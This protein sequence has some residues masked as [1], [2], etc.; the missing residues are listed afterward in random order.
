MNEISDEFLDHEEFLQVTL[1]RFDVSRPE[2]VALR[3]ALQKNTAEDIASTLGISAAAVRK[4]LGAVYQ[5]FKIP[6]T[7]PGKLESLRGILIDAF[8]EYRST[9]KQEATPDHLDWGEAIS[10][11]VFYDR[12]AELAQLKKFITTDR[13]RLVALWGIGGIGKTTLAVKAAEM[14]QSAFDCIIWRSLSEMPT[15]DQILEDWLNILPKRSAKPFET[16]GHK[17]TYLIEAIKEIPCLF[18]LDNF[19]AVLENNTPTGGYCKGYSD[20]GDLLH[21]VGE[22]AHQSCLLVISREKPLEV[23]ALES[24]K[25]H[26]RVLK[27]KGS[28]VAALAILDDKGLVGSREDKQALTAR[29]DH[30]PL[31]I[32]IAATAIQDLFAGDIATFLKEQSD[33]VNTS[34]QLVVGN[35]RKLLDEQ[36]DQVSD[37]E[38]SILYWLAIA[39]EPLSLKDLRQDLFIPTT[40]PSQLIDALERL[41]RRSLLEKV[42]G[43]G[44]FHLQN[45]MMEYVTDRLVT[46]ICQEIQTK[47]IKI[48]NSHALMKANAKAYIRDIQFRLILSP[49]AQNLQLLIG[50]SNLHDWAEQILS[51]LRQRSQLAQGYAAGNLLNLLVQLESP[52]INYDFSNLCIRHADLRAAQLRHINFSD[53]NLRDCCF[54][55]TFGSVLNVA[56]SADG[57]TLVAGAADSEI[58]LW[59]LRGNQPIHSFTGHTDWVWATAYDSAR[60]LLAS[61]SADGEV[62]LWD[63]KAGNCLWTLPRHYA[64]VWYVA[65]LDAGTQV[66]SGSDDGEVRLWHIHDKRLVKRLS[67][68]GIKTRSLAVSPDGK[69]LVRGYYD[70]MIEVVNLALEEQAIQVIGHTNRIMAL[71]F[72]PS[73]NWLA[74]ADERGLINIWETQGWSRCNTVQNLA[75]RVRA[76]AF[77]PQETNLVSGGD[78]GLLHLWER[79]TE[80]DQCRH[81][82]TLEGHK[83]W[84]WSV[85]YSPDGKML[86]SG[87]EDQ[88]IKLWESHTGRCLSTLQG[89]SNRVLGIAVSPKGDLLAYGNEDYSVQLSQIGTE[90][91]K[92]A[93]LLGHNNRVRSVAFSPLSVAPVSSSTD[94]PLDEQQYLASSSDD[95]SVKVWSLATGACLYSFTAHKGW[96][97]TVAFSPDS[98]SIASGSDDRTIRVWSLADG[99]SI[100]VLNDHQEAV[101][102]V[103]FGVDPAHLI[104]GSE[105]KTIKI[106]HIP[107][108]RCIKTL[109]EHTSW[110][111]CVAI[112]P[113]GQKLASSGA[114]KQILIWDLTTY[115]LL[116]TLQGHS[117]PVRSVAFSP[118]SLRLA[119][120]SDDKTVR[121]WDLESGQVIKSL[122]GHSR[123]VSS[124]AF[125]PKDHSLFSSGDQSIRR[126]DGQTGAGLDIFPLDRPYQGLKIN[127]V[128]GL[129][130]AQTINLKVLGATTDTLFSG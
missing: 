57:K 114:D 2:M 96:V 45:V 6:G 10:A 101:L 14:M 17:I 13:C 90:Q 89:R 1:E 79:V 78:D 30:N 47:Q 34:R 77:N 104:S 107:S 124:V 5:K 62:R 4:R 56:F 33:S 94:L 91:S 117:A 28:E 27:V 55:E 9:Q 25:Q 122:Y 83:N 44:A 26:T 70:G 109:Q 80:P 41:S 51:Q 103:A 112:S 3:L 111:L 81:V 119:S 59:R 129:T 38:K 126:W 8:N 71:G 58:R 12:T 63:T 48:F 105:D 15:L 49:I 31:A 125:S 75:A 92:T 43:A 16:I 42:E 22:S 67:G 72:S 21:R 20:Y 113:D 116:H 123:Y 19:E 61:G 118:D 50:A 100:A 24:T 18:V 87:S 95:R 29:Y 64:R 88:S 35:L 86:A 69:W 65:L 39:R 84:I 36:F 128:S 121:L 53:A 98:Q 40:S 52:L 66:L 130:P 60:D 120:G 46:T 54:S 11:G 76:V 23:T 115:Q 102:S 73:G 110:V 7:T 97:R 99:Q 32:K 82:R 68:R 106:W 85:A 93:Q 74:S 108:K 127:N 37:L